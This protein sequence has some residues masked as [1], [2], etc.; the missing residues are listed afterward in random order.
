IS[1][2]STLL[3]EA[4]NRANHENE[5]Q[6][7]SLLHKCY[8]PNWDLFC[9]SRVILEGCGPERSERAVAGRSIPCHSLISHKGISTG[10]AT[11]ALAPGFRVQASDCSAFGWRARNQ[12]CQGCDAARVIVKW[13]ADKKALR[14]GPMPVIRPGAENAADQSGCGRRWVYVVDSGYLARSTKGAYRPSFDRSTML[15]N[16]SGE[17]M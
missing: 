1:D 11:P 8:L 5:Y 14:S 7:A 3:G 12:V 16:L 17:P 10:T 13:M 6:E 2:I 15:M 4:V 9:F